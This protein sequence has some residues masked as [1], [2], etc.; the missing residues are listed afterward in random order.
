MSIEGDDIGVRTGDDGDDKEG[1]FEKEG[2][3]ALAVPGALVFLP[4]V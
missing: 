1:G 4:V 3:A 2:E